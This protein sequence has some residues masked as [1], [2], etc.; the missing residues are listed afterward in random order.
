MIP[1]TAAIAIDESEIDESFVRASGPGG[2]NV[3]KL[4]TAVR[5]RFDAR[6]SPSLPEAVR[7]RL[8]RL[9]GRRLTRDGVII[10][11]AQRHRTQER[12]RE[13]ALQRLIELIRQAA[14]PP[15]SRRPTR[16]GTGER[17]R[18]LEEKRRRA[19]IKSLRSA[20]PIE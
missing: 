9:A 3:Q 8:Q 5:L 20:P 17:K 14:E 12:N 16:V 6:S 7:Q 11:S 13:D 2:Q 19:E 1:I 10:I 15:A 18:R 4:S